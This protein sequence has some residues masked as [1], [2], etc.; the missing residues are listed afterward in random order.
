MKKSTK[1]LSVILAIVM[2]F[3]SMSI[4]A[5]AAKANYKTVA[6]L[7][8][9]QAYS[10]Y[11]AVTRLSTEERTSILFDYLDGILE[12][13]N[14]NMGKLFDVAGLSL[15]IDLRSLNAALGTI[16]NV[17]SLRNNSLVK[18][19]A[20]MLGILNDLDVSTWQSGMT[21]E[22]VDQ[23][24]IVYELVEFLNANKGVVSNVIRTGEVDLGV[25]SS[26]LSGL[27]LS[28]IKDIPGLIKG[29]IYPMF[30]RWDDSLDRVNELSNTAGDGGME[31]M[32][33]DFVQRLFTNNMS[34]TSYREDASGNCVSNHTLPTAE[35]TRHYYTKGSDAK[36]EYIQVVTYNTTSKQYVISDEN[37]YY[38]TSEE[39]GSDKYV[40][41]KTND[42]GSKENLKYYRND[43]QFLPSFAA[44]LAS[45]AVTLDLTKDT[46]AELLYK[47]IPYVFGEMAPVVLNGSVKKLFAGLLGAQFTYV[48]EVGSAEVK[49]LAD[50]N[51]VFFTQAQGDYLWEWSDY[52]VINGNHYY[53]FEDQIF[54]TDLNDVNKFFSLINWDWNVTADAINEFVPGADGTKSA[55]GYS[56]LFQALNDFV[57][58]VLDIAATPELKALVNW[59][60]GDNSK[61][62]T[63]IKNAARAL[64]PIE[65][66]II[67]GSN[68]ADPDRYYDLIMTGNDQEILVGVACTLLDFLMPQLIL[69]KADAIKG[70]NVKLGAVLAAVVRELATQFLPTY[71]YDALIYADYN[72]KAFVAGK[73]NS[74]W[75]DVCLTMGVDIGMS[76][77]R[78]LADLGEDTAVGYK[79]VESKTYTAAN[80]D[81]KGWEAT[82]DWVL[83]WALC[84][85]YEWCWSMD[86]F[87]DCTDEVNLATAQDPWVKLGDILYNLLPVTD[88]LNVDI[89][90]PAWAEVALRDNLVLAIL[91]L[92]FTK[93]TGST[94]ANGIFNIPVDSVLRTKGTLPAVVSV[95]RDTLNN[96]LY[97]VAGGNLIDPAVITDLDSLLNQSNL[98]SFVE[99][100][101]ARLFTAY[102]NGL[103]DP[104]MPFLGFF[105]GWTT[106]AQTMSD[107]T[108]KLTNQDDQEYMYTN[109]LTV[110]ST[111]T[112]TNN[113][114]GMLLKHRTS[115]ATDHDYTL[116]VDR[117]EGE[118]TTS[119]SLPI[120]IEPGAKGTIEL[121]A[122]YTGDK[123]V[124]FRVIYH[125]VFKDGSVSSTQQRNA[126]NYVANSK[127]DIVTNKY[128]EYASSSLMKPINKSTYSVDQNALVTRADEFK[129]TIGN[130][131]VTWGNT[132]DADITYKSLTYS[133]YDT[134]YIAS[135]G[136]AE[137][138]NNTNFGQKSS[139]KTYVAKVK[140]D[141]DISKLASGST[142]ELGTEVAVF[143][144]KYGPQTDTKT[145]TVNLGKLY[146]CDFSELEDLF[147]AER[148]K[149]RDGANYGAAEWNAYLTAMYDTASFVM[150]PKKAATF[151]SMY[152]DAAIAE[153]TAALKAAV[154]NLEESVASSASAS[155]TTLSNALAAAETGENEIN[156][157]DYNLYE[158]FEYQDER[159]AVRNRINE[160]AGPK[161]P[162]NRIDGSSLTADEIEAVIAG[163]TG[164]KALGIRNTVVAPTAE[165]VEAYQAA[166]AEWKA[167]S[168]TDLDN[169]NKAMMLKYYKTFLEKKTAE[170][171]F[172]TKEIAYAKA[173]NYNSSLYSAD[174]W[175][176]YT[177]A[178]ATAEQVAADSNALQSTV[179]DAK[180]GLMK[181]QN[182][183]LLK[184]KSVK[185]LGLLSNLESLVAQAEIIFNNSQ[186][187]A[188]VAGIT[189][190]DA[191]GAL[192]KAV[193][194]TLEDGSI[195]YNRSAAEFLKYD[196]ENTAT[197]MERIKASE[198]ALKAA[199][200]NFECTIKLEEKD[201]NQ[202]TTVT[203]GTK[204]IDGITPGTIATVEALM[205]HVKTSSPDAIATPFASDSGFFGTG[206]KVE[207][208]VAG[209]GVLT[210]Y[211][212]VIYGDVNGDGAIDAFD[213][214][215][216]DQTV[217]TDAEL[218][219][220]Y[221]DAAMVTGGDDVALADYS[222]IFNA[223][224]GAQD[225]AQN[226]A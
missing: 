111:L 15:T 174:S 79:F 24:T 137:E 204:I 77:L 21:R 220:V 25:A 189:E 188:P 106:D 32:L 48:G 161:A 126:F 160:Y 70:Q 62:I 127:S 28:I 81:P 7:E 46:P 22:S 180:Y 197:N 194:Y 184:T 196:R 92:D 1:L 69:P 84:S 129:S 45:G 107:P 221:K 215:V 30:N 191:Y 98:A 225:I 59:Q 213:A 91:D 66:E 134:D 223:S 212:V 192:I 109:S 148:G 41:V 140:P 149:V 158:Y 171:Q 150:Q 89:S 20:W 103:L 27:D 125:Y 154:A 83:D 2:L 122:P 182:E 56:T 163:A 133:G 144:C 185:E 175:A 85:E 72:N 128:E 176:D 142:L 100:L 104:V 44:D 207:V 130:L 141:A 26:A 216:V 181:A 164:K 178:L 209:I 143:T 110:S 136:E 168:Y 169:E 19:V 167:P 145:W 205:E 226:R 68:Y 31:A 39:D 115:S 119:T 139:I 113:S 5:S 118:M 200:D 170:K 173:Q 124:Y 155:V 123:A 63:N 162:E 195:L 35:G 198:A 217:N 37:R 203:Q 6:D 3:S 152:T 11:G 166:K 14:I 206:A 43:S 54:S 156:Y 108:L 199:I 224:V 29:L 101:L 179:F 222:A 210:T 211:Y 13:A 4:M 33:N 157:Q 90:D 74:Y 120:S 153:K 49:A 50:S 51:D 102:N 177:A 55:A 58:K 53:R 75:L 96:A 201:E 121:S 105:V 202:S 186:Y 190:A 16:D 214:A 78:G 132:R 94:E 52:K 151:T 86:K 9:N 80:F 187:Y 8:A 208:S 99:T 42:D 40:F 193:G 57:A 38:K 219:G 114:S 95:I 61:L 146:Y 18:L 165:E 159:T 131:G 10:P 112:V 36:G 76:Y 138:V 97:K 82:I 183:L 65:P 172:L 93:I 147:M 12:T 64:L 218:D 17:K 34:I 60:R 71:N 23:T 116:V 67:F 73:D 117:I 87:V 88:L 135:S 47:F